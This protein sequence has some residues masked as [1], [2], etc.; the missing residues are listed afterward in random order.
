MKSRYGCIFG[1]TLLML[2][3]RALSQGMLSQI[4]T[5]G[6]TDKR[7]NIVFLAEGY[8]Q[9]QTNQFAANARTLLNNLLGT[10]NIP[11]PEGKP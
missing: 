7:I 9:N 4:L 8:L 2:A 3:P 5:S 1:M 6:P 10:F 11:N